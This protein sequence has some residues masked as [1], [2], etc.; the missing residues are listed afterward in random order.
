MRKRCYASG[1]EMLA[2]HDQFWCSPNHMNTLRQ[3]YLD[4]MIWIAEHEVL[5]TILSQITGE[6]IV[7]KKLSLDLP[8]LMKNAEYFLS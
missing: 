8:K 7:Y 2:V 1:F 3:H 6:D 4:I 5:S